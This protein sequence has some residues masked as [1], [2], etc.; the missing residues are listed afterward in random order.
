MSSNTVPLFD[1]ERLGAPVLHPSE[2]KGYGMGRCRKK[3][4]G[5]SLKLGQTQSAR[6]SWI[7]VNR[8]AQSTV[9]SVD[10]GI[11]TP[12]PI[13]HPKINLWRIFLVQEA[14]YDGRAGPSAERCQEQTVGDWLYVSF[15]RTPD[16]PVNTFLFTYPNWE[17]KKSVIYAGCGARR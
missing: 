17:K 1:D 7:L 14:G 3:W 6:Q 11:S 10:R 16:Y 5:P 4:R 9:G 8:Y 2:K 13:L 15:C 12:S